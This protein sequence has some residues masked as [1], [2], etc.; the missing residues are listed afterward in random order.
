MERWYIPIALFILLAAWYVFG[1]AM[2]RWNGWRETA[3]E[4]R[5]EKDHWRRKAVWLA[6]KLHRYGDG[7]ER[8]PD[9]PDGTRREHDNYRAW[10]TAADAATKE[11]L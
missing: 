8:F 11:G 7:V 10:L 6:C 3:H 9:R 2:H 1:M 4:E 5:A